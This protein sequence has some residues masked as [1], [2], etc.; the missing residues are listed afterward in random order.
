V[1]Y[2]NK[3][4]YYFLD[5]YDIYSLEIQKKT[6]YLLT[7]NLIGL[8]GLFILTSI[9]FFTSFNMYFLLGDISL[10]TFIISSLIFIRL[11]NIHATSL[12]VIFIL[13]A[14]FFYNII[15]S[16][17]IDEPLA[18]DSLFF[19]LA[20]MIF[21]IFYLSI[22]SIRRSSLLIFILFS[23]T[24][25][26]LN[27]Y[28]IINS[29]GGLRY[30]VSLL[31]NAFGALVGLLLS[32]FLA[33]KIQSYT[34]IVSKTTEDALIES[35]Q[36]YVSLFSNIEDAF[37]FVK[38]LTDDLGRPYDILILEVNKAGEEL[39][40]LKREQIVFRKFTEILKSKLFDHAKW[41]EIIFKVA[42]SGKETHH[43][44]F[45]DLF[46]K[47]LYV[48]TFSPEEGYC[49]LLFR[50]ITEKVEADT[51]LKKTQERN[52]ALLDAIPDTI[53]V[54]DKEGVITD[55][56]KAQSNLIEN[57]LLFKPGKNISNNNLPDDL[58]TNLSDAIALVKKNRTRKTIVLEITTITRTIYIE[59]R[60]V[61]LGEDEVLIF[62][63]DITSRKLAEKALIAAKEKAE[64]SDK[65]KMA[66]LSNMSHEIRT[67]MNAII[68]FSE[69][70]E[71]PE[72]DEEEKND[73]LYQIRSNGKLLLNLINDILDLSKIEAGQLEI[74]MANFDLNKVLHDIYINFENEKTVKHK[75]RISLILEKPKNISTLF[76]N[77][78]EYRFKQILFNLMGNALKFTE[79]GFITLGY[80]IKDNNA[81]I[82]VKDS[83]IGIPADKLELVFQR[84]RQV[85]DSNTRTFGG[86]GLGLTITKNLVEALGGKIWVE[87]K[88]K[89]GSE[90]YFTIPL[91][92]SGINA[93]NHLV[94]DPCIPVYDWSDR[95][96]LIIE[97]ETADYVVLKHILSKTGV[98]LEW[99]ANAASALNVCEKH[100]PD[101]VIIDLEVTLSQSG[102]IESH[103]KNSYPSIR[104][105]ALKPGSLEEKALKDT[106]YYDQIIEKPIKARTLLREI[107]KFM[108]N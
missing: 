58:K 18:P 85:D 40:Q 44:L 66:F 69:M 48:Q 57:D 61:P 107:N 54:C 90:F 10:Y 71:Y 15:Y 82:Y 105:I 108:I 16:L 3:I 84:F 55:Y 72:I 93:D 70:L 43:T 27:Y 64:E 50:D 53:I 31:T 88:E 60:I 73:F 97:G 106:N 68:G 33:L 42:L 98:N 23:I 1:R 101:L 46:K 76:I 83:G 59:T 104:I 81:V 65:L 91:T 7:F 39:L 89:N 80:Q 5:G 86:A 8:C 28:F 2:W 79:K 102:I 26:A 35:R 67:P 100:Y 9:R 51:V 14:A 11:K 41:L 37:G 30:S 20:Y 78:D 6:E 34:A 94:A 74:T 19:S 92:N 96:V 63:R 87:S 103:L 95:S 22:F 29:V 32:Y 4:K 38:V 17:A 52:N 45:S 24:I 13:F 75:N 12:T 62:L 21:G 49:V 25:L 47:W 77:S 99:G 56:K 36:Q